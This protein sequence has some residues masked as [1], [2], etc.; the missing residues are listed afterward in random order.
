MGDFP[1]NIVLFDLDGTLVDSNLDLAPAIN[2]ALSLEGRPRVPNAEVRQLI[3]GGAI[4][5]LERALERSGGP[6]PQDRFEQLSDALLEHYWAHI[7]DN[8]V[9]FEGVLGALDLLA[10]RGCKLAVCTN[11]AEA[12]ARQ[13][14]DALDLTD[15]FAAIYGG[16][17][18]GRER[19]KPAPDMLHAAIADCGGGRAALVGDSTYDVRAARNAGLPVVTYR[20]GYHDVPVDELGG[21]IMIDHFDELVGVLA[22]L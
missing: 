22:D 12:P 6:V 11:K 15:R 4:L 7:A 5:M 21:D 18:L 13:L 19:A 8:T 20:Y 17:T 1:F 16:D 10:E 3:G 14:L 9:P 2:H